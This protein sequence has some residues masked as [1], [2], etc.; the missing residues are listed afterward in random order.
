[1]GKVV[2]F[3]SLTLD[4]VMQA[5]ARSDEDTRGGFRYGGWAVPYADAVMGVFI[6]WLRRP[7]R[8]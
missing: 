3:T 1:M 5:P 2:L 8:S 6:R 7:R 4:G